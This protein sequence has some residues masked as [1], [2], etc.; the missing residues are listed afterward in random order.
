MRDHATIVRD[1]GAQALVRLLSSAGL[2]I[3]QSTPQ[4]WADRSSIPGEYWATLAEKGV[5]TL[6]ELAA[7]AKPRK[8][9]DTDEPQQ[10][11]A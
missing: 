3:H 9:G 1:Y 2:E 7:G 8:R 11:A 4:R 5:A 10:A 6:E